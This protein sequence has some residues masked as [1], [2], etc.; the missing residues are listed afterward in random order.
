MTL[1]RY[2]KDPRTEQSLRHSVRDGVAYSFMTGAGETYFSAYALFLK[3]TTAQISWLAAFPSLMGSFAQ[4]IS[5]WL[6][7]HT[8]RRKTIIL[9]GVALQTLM[10]L[11]ITWLPYFFPAHAVPIM[12]ACVALY[13]AGCHLAA[14]AW[15]S[16][17]GD[18]VPER[19][20]GRFFARRG[21]V[22]SI[23]M[24][25]ALVAAGVMLHLGKTEEHTRIAFTLV[26]SLAALARVYSALQL[27]RMHDPLP[28][29]HPLDLPPLAGWW[30]RL[31][32]SD[33]ARFT[34]F[35]GTMTFAVA[36][37]SPFF[38][39]FMLR[40]LHFTYLQYMAALAFSVLLQFLTLRT[41]GRLG[42]IFGNR[43]ILLVTGC[44]IP[45]FPVL[46]LVSS[47][48]W[49][50]LTLQAMGGICWAGFSLSGSNYL[51]DVSMPER[52]A[53]F[54]AV[55]NVLSSL[56]LFGGALFGGFL[57]LV[58]PDHIILFGRSI[59]WTSSLWA[60]MLVSTL[61]RTAVALGFLPRLREMRE[62]RRLTPAGLMLRVARF[63]A[64]SEMFFNVLALTRRRLRSTGPA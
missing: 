28:V 60:L 62:V 34:L 56:A 58:A 3:A 8:G 22:M 42:D 18:L 52:R 45:M 35:M 49:Y 38:T 5:A 11:P 20:R 14:P 57:S 10:W 4:L 61:A 51:Y 1:L 23:T 41:W 33:F 55:H 50:I 29:P 53:A 6:A 44:M 12:I 31:R 7:S 15:N 39:V 32:S 25:A 48:Y 46:W 36:I 16:L 30:A 64:L 37:A 63:N 9:T 43:L 19:R 24:F 21:R 59:T 47:K 13:Y 27:A 17:M 54:S 40:D 2:S 26:F